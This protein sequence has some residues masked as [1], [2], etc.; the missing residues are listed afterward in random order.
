MPLMGGYITYVAP[1]SMETPAPP[2]AAA[3]AAPLR[4]APHAPLRRRAL[5]PRFRP[6][7]AR[8]GWI[9]ALAVVLAWVLCLPAS[10]HPASAIIGGPPDIPGL[11]HALSQ[12]AMRGP[13]GWA[14]SRFMMYPSIHNL[15]G[16][17]SF[18]ADGMAAAPFVALLGW[19]TGFTVFAVLTLALAGTTAGL[20]AA[21][22]WRS[23]AS[24]LLGVVA[25]ETSGIVLREI[26]EG[27]LT[28][29][30]GLALAPLA[31]A[32]YCRGVVENRGR[33]SF[34]AG[35][36]VGLSALV[37]WYQA[38]WLALMLLPIFAVGA[39]E[40]LPVVRHTVWGAMGAGLIAGF[41]LLYTVFHAG[42]HPGSQVGP[43]DVVEQIPGEPMYLI[44]LLEMRDVF[45]MGIMDGSWAIRPLLVAA[46]V[47]GATR[48]P[49]RRIFLPVVWIATGWALGEGPVLSIPGLKVLSP[50]LL[51]SFVPLM[52]RYWWPDR[53][54]LV[55]CLGAV[56]L[57]SGLPAWLA[58]R[59]RPIWHARVVV[60][61]ALALLVEAWFTLPNL[62]MPST[63]G[64]DPDRVAALASGSGPLL[65]VPTRELDQAVGVRAWQSNI[66]LEQIAHKRPLL[67]GP[68]NPEAI[69]AGT[70]YQQFWSTGVLYEIRAC[71]TISGLPD[72]SPGFHE[73][74]AESLHRLYRAGLHEI[75]ADPSR[76][77]PAEV[78]KVWRGCL[79]DLMG[80]PTGTAGPFRVY[81]VPP[82]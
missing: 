16:E 31:L 76:E 15:Y 37:F 82:P 36:A 61:A 73:A 46:I 78:A 35:T 1:G 51:Q 59:V 2:E 18:P 23:L 38:V 70:L 80:A 69:V 3:D 43:W 7:P 24:G 41:P 30:L 65:M 57:V 40:R 20:L 33:W 22:W 63:P 81:A 75:Y 8:W 39:F 21:S 9:P 56:L 34:L 4:P 58:G 60:A 71:E 13:G 64:P 14:H 25:L 44:V 19:P 28:H 74:I 48:R 79:E 50:V 12:I 53:Y 10:A 52:R 17:M 11:A 42:S 32:A 62:P 54:L 6:L 29:V 47:L 45:G 55:A 27:R 66:L 67:G 68:M 72:R 5:V 49:L 77:G 26:A